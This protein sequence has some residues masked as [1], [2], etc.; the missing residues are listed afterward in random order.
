VLKLFRRKISYIAAAAACLLLGFIFYALSP[1]SA[2]R[3]L[4]LQIAGPP[5]LT[6]GVLIVTVVLSNETT[7]A[8]NI[9]DDT[10]GNP[11]FILDDYNH[12]DNEYVAR[13]GPIG[14]TLKLNLVSGS[15]ITN[16]V[17][18]TNAP[19]R[20]RLRAEVRDLA[21]ERHRPILPSRL[22]ASVAS[23]LPRRWQEKL[24]GTREIPMATSEWI[25]PKITDH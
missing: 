22:G 5:R 14:N 18:I 25:E 17:G 13:L 21:A 4:Q 2:S 1:P 10:A 6:N 8:L 20:F 9:I 12:P 15:S 16:T 3:T 7:R 24:N 23:V 11:N 19:T